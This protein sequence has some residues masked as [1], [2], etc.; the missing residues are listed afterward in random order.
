MVHGVGHGLFDGGVGKVLYARGF[1]PVGVFDDGFA[2]VVSPNVVQRL[3][4]HASQRAPEGLLREPIASRSFRKP[5][6]VYL[7][8]REESFRFRVEEEQPDV[9][10][11]EGLLR[12]IDNVHLPSQVRHGQLPGWAGQRA[13]D[14]IQKPDNQ[15][16][17]QVVKSSALVNA[18]VERHSRR[19][20]E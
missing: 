19:Q 9:L 15:V 2:D 1:G 7:G 4:G 20:R 18:I 13:T 11:K 17:R 14:L 3:A 12:A 10:G 6:N 5:D 16:A 8:G